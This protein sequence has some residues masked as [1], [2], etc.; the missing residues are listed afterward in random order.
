[1]KFSA[2][3]LRLSDIEIVYS[4]MNYIRITKIKKK[5]GDQRISER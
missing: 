3:E 2:S 5:N 4:Y 1:M